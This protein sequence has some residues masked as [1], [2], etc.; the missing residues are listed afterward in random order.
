MRR[1]RLQLR[2]SSDEEEEEGE[3]TGTSGI[4]DSSQR[5]GHASSVQP[6]TSVASN[7]NPNPGETIAVSEVEII[8]VF[9]NPQ[10]TPPDSSIPTPYPVYP[11]ESESELVRGNNYESPISEVLS[12][13]GI[14]LKREWWVSCL[15]GL[16]TSIP[17]FS[18]LDVAA[19]AKHCFEQFMFSDMN[20]C[21]AGVLPRNVASMN[22]IELAGPFVLQVDEIVN[23]GCPLKG[24]YEN[25]NA[26]LKRCLKLSMTDGVQRVFGM[27][28]RPIK[29]LQ[30]LAP[31]GLK[32][33]VSSVQVRHGLL[34]LV[35][36]IVEVL[37]GMVEE[38]EEARKR[39]VV[40][41]N[42]PPRGKRTRIGVVPSLTT[43]ATLA[44]WSL[45]GND[46]G[47]HVDSSTS[48][49]A[50]HAQANPQGIPVNVTRTHI[51][52]RA[53][54][55]HPASTNVEATVS[56]VEHMQIDTASAHGERTFSGI[57]STSSNIHRPASTA[58]TSC[59]GTRSFSNNVGRNTLDQQTSNVTSFVEEMHI[60][61]GRVRDTTS[62]VYGSGSGGVADA[63]V[64]NKI[65]DLEGPSVMSTNTEKPFTYLAELSQKWA[66]MKDTIHF[67]QGRI[68]CFLTGVKK[69]QFKQQS[70]YELLCYV[71]D[72]SLICEILLHN[73]VVQ[74]RIGHTSMEV[75]AALSS[76]APTSVNAMM[77]EK[78]KRFQ[79][80][81]ADFEGIMMVEMNRSSQY[82]V[83]IE[84]NQGCSLTDARLLL[85]RIKS[86]SRTS[87]SLNPVVVL[88]P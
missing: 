70:T 59:S 69:F 38:L 33:V 74:K 15:S 14:K 88:S 29:D 84:M 35:P 52:S 13:M 57:H 77:K 73:D 71:D 42:K 83:A 68:K 27:E 30:V 1:R 2:Y 26:G 23:I 10:P 49:N 31:A 41:V 55:E 86:S 76:S 32:V 8:D 79:L 44:A 85:E 17:Q 50:S 46:T 62:H 48:G 21:G 45:N 34:M 58:G 47:N 82:P 36:E 40:E 64:S 5:I 3:E 9:G 78:L 67:V 65:V 7:S 4:G 51:S 66:V 63:E 87:S 24:R 56:R 6:E 22:L 80:F 54:D 60:D 18:Y 39:L 37:G 75:T 12:R 61:T 43:R 81:L 28:Y 11:S 20:L 19:K 53:M 72:G 16:E 25:A